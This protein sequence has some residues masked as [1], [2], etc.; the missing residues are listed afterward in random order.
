LQISVA[1][2]NLFYLPFEEALEIIVEAGFQAV[3]LDLYWE[4]KDWAM[5]Q[6]LKGRGIPEVVRLIRQSGLKVTSIH[7]GGGVLENA[8]S[9]LGFVNPQL[10]EYLDQLGYTPD[11]IVF[12]TPHIEGDYDQTW[13]QSMRTPIAQTANE[14]RRNGTRVT[15][16][17]MPAFE[18]YTIPL[19]TPP[20]LFDFVAEHGLGVTLDTTHYAEAGIDITQAARC[21]KGKI[22]TIHLS[23][24]TEGSRHVLVGDGTLDFANFF[25]EIDFSA[26]NAV[27]LECSVAFLN[28]NP[29]ELSRG[30]RIERLKIARERLDRWLPE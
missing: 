18:G 15:L 7:D 26:L 6:H 13:W 10:G 30:A 5:A 25:R 17:N 2:A 24:Y 9:T 4:R 14:Y 23:D 8:D 20:E 19:L 21:L 27:T 29:R 16:E 11:C 1:T 22:N 3:E 12:H 28:E